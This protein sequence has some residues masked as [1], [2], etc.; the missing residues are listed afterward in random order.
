MSKQNTIKLFLYHFICYL[1]L[2]HLITSF[3]QKLFDGYNVYCLFFNYV[4][5]RE[6]NA[7]L[8]L[9]VNGW[10]DYWLYILQLRLIMWTI[11]CV[12]LAST[13]NW[14][15]GCSL[16]VLQLRFITSKMYVLLR[17]LYNTILFQQLNYLA[18]TFPLHEGI[19]TSYDFLSPT[20]FLL[21]SEEV[22]V[23]HSCIIWSAALFPPFINVCS[24]SRA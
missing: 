13:C 11:I 2:P 18:H 17:K 9:L 8:F 6:Q 22:H 10:N 4:L 7:L 14:W 15:L 1:M 16:F 3:F 5:L 21:D 24:E 20:T 12:I 19:T 23:F